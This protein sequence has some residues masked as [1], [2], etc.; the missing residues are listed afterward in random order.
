MKALLA[1]LSGEALRA[2]AMPEDI[3]ARIAGFDVV[4]AVTE[5]GLH[6]FP[7]LPI[8]DEYERAEFKRWVVAET[9]KYV[10]QHDRMQVAFSR[11]Y[12]DARQA[13]H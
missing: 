13:L 4:D 10:G 2:I 9:L 12:A 8:D 3:A 5:R 1:F 11:V 7:A 6:R